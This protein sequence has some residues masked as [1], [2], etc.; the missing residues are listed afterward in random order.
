MLYPEVA[1]LH[2]DNHNI[3][4]LGQC[5]PDAEIIRTALTAT[6]A[7]VDSAV[8]LIYLGPSP[9]SAQ[10]KAL[11]RLAPYRERIRELIEEG[12]AFLFTHNALEILGETLQT[13]DG[14]EVAGLGLFPLRTRLEM[15]NRYSGKVLG[16]AGLGGDPVQIVGYKTQFSFVEAAEDLPGFLTAERGIGRNRQTRVEGVRQGNFIGTS[17]VGPL[18]I[19][20][21]EF[22]KQL[23][24]V[25]DPDTEP[26][27]AHEDLI[28][29]AYQARL[30]DFTDP[31]RWHPWEQLES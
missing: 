18:L 19:N 24:A 25:L 30:A 11:A 16:R 26:T 7:F 5:R 9:E 17:L 12:T 4:Y 14:S 2:G 13:A 6:P 10:V 15:L 27:L 1:N 28:M 3:V 20:N 23:L 8:D 31:K 22:T 29:S 21:P